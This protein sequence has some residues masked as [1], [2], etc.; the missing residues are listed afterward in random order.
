MS[1]TINCLRTLPVIKSG[2]ASGADGLAAEHFLKG[3]LYP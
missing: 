3:V 2:K 1:G